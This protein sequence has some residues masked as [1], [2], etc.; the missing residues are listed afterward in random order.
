MGTIDENGDLLPSTE[1]LSLLDGRNY[2]KWDG[3]RIVVIDRSYPEAIKAE[4][5]RF[6][7][8]S[9]P[10]AEKRLLRSLAKHG[11]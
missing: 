7:F 6:A 1:Q 10:K 11:L 2:R 3:T 5:E 4:R 9:L 8:A